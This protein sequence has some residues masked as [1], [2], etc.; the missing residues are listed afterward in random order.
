MAQGH[1]N[2]AMPPASGLLADLFGFLTGAAHYIMLIFMVWRES[3]AAGVPV[4]ASRGRLPFATGVCGLVWNLG[5]MATL[6]IRVFGIDNH[7]PFVLAVAFT[8]L[9][10]LPAVI[11]HSLLQGRE[12]AASRTLIRCVTFAAYTL[13]AVA[14]VLHMS[15][16]L[17]GAAVPSRP[18]LW[19]LTTGFIVLMGSL[20]LLTRQQAGRRRGIWIGALAIFS[21]SAVHFSRH[22][23]NETWWLELATHHASLP[24]ALAILIQDYRFGF[25]D[26]FL[27]NALAILGVMALTISLWAGMALPLLN[28]ANANALAE[29]RLVALF[30]LLWTATA[31][32]AP[33]V[34]RGAAW[35]V[36]RAVFRRPDYDVALGDL[37]HAIDSA[38]DEAAIIDHLEHAVRSALGT[39]AAAMVADPGSVGRQH[40]ALSAADL[41]GGSTG[42]ALVLRLQTVDAPHR[43]LAFRALPAG[44]RLLS[45]DLRWLEAATGLAARRIDAFR[46]AQERVEH[47]LREQAIRRLATEAELRALRA[48]LNPHFLFN[49]LTTIGHLIETAPTRAIDTL[50]RL[51]SVLRG[52]LRRSNVEFS[53][54]GDEIVFVQSY[55]EIERA[56]FE[57]RLRVTIDV[58]R[59][60]LD[61]SIPTL[62]LQPLVEN[63]VKHGISPRRAGGEVTVS[64]RLDESVLELRVAD[65]GAGFEASAR[66]ADGVGLASVTDRL[67]A[68]YGADATFDIDSAPD[69]GTRIVIRLPAR[70]TDRRD[71]DIAQRRAG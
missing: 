20:I 59:A 71:A 60:L 49:A 21:V 67:R 44:R 13:S 51:T 68:H 58:P 22:A 57:E 3:A 15:A 37:A 62:I 46:V 35:V 40:L 45:D 33:L 14:A 6:G 52:V 56:R 29:P 39:D 19:L 26:L 53:S 32:A 9:G 1:Y 55:L 34:R 70:G 47:N 54:L 5:A 66:S 18:A 65:S 28:R 50:L 16:A 8:A 23:G 64:A 43:A 10:M 24:L 38:D 61:L 30:A 41:R 12:T 63:A 11:V 48:Q 7:Q 27:K 4:L 17:R 31:L 42:A 36:D 25:A 2:D 69:R